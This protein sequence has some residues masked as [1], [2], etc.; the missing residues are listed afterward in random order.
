VTRNLL[1]ASLSLV[2]AFCSSAST[3]GASITYNI[4]NYPSLQNGLTLSG[5]ITTD[6]TIGVINTPNIRAWSFT[7][8]GPDGTTENSTKPGATVTAYNVTATSSQL[9]MAVL[10]NGGSSE[11]LFRDSTNLSEMTY[12]RTLPSFGS[13]VYNATGNVFVLWSDSPPSSQ[14]GGDPWIV[15]QTVPEP[16]SLTLALL[17]TACPALVAWTRRHRVT[18]SR[19]LRY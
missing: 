18:S 16:G 7:I 1:L 9:L 12:T 4:Q 11:L 8:S 15:A 6:G 10:P 13:D 14:L 19:P 3:R 5:T 17:G 2:L